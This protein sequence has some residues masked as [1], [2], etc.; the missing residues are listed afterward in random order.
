MRLKQWI[1]Q[2]GARWEQEDDELGSELLLWA[3]TRIVV[4]YQIMLASGR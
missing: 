3:V 1:K 2:R 4:G